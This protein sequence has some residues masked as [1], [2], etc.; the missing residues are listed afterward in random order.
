MAYRII[1]KETDE[2]V[3]C[4]KCKGQRW[5]VITESKQYGKAICEKCLT[6]ITTYY[7]TSKYKTEQAK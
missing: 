6:C 5:Y 2:T 7:D 3:T 1:N 4:S